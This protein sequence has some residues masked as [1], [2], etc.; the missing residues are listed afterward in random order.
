VVQVFVWS[1]IIHYVGES[2]IL[3]LKEAYR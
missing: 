2:W 3:S 1:V